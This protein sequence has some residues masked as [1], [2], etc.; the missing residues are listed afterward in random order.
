MSDIRD[1]IKAALAECAAAT[2]RGFAATSEKLLNTLGYRSERKVALSGN[3]AEF[4]RAYPATET[5]NADKFRKDAANVNIVFQFAESEI[6]D[7]VQRGLLPPLTQFRKKDTASFLFVAADLRPKHYSR[8]DYADFVREINKRFNAPTVALFR[9]P[10]SKDTTAALTLAFVGRRQSKTRRGYD[11]LQKVS[12]LREIQCDH[13]HRGHLDILAQLSLVERFNWMNSENKSQNFDG[14]L[15]AWLDEL[16]AEALNRR[17]YKALYRWFEWARNKAVFPRLPRVQPDRAATDAVI[18]L[19]TRMM[20]IWFIKEKKLVADELFSENQISPLLANYDAVKGDTYYRAILQNLF[21][22]TLNTEIRRRGFNLEG[23]P[24]HRNGHGYRYKTLMANPKKILELMKQTPFINGGLF[25]CL[26]S[27]EGGD[28][29]ADMFSDPIPGT[30]PKAAAARK[31][32]FAKLSVPNFLFFQEKKDPKEQRGLLAIFKKYKFTVEE[33]TPVEQEV[34]LDPELLG[35]VFENLLA[36]VNPET[37]ESARNQTGSFYTPRAI[38]DY[39]TDESIVDYLAAKVPGNGQW[40]QKLRDLLDYANSEC[41]PSVKE[42]SA[43]LVGAI[44][45][46]KVLDPACGSGAFPMGVL[47]KLALALSKLDPK[48]K[49]WKKFQKKRATVAARKIFDRVRG[50]ETRDHRL[51][52]I[53]NTFTKYSKPFGRKIFLIQNSIFGA[54]IQPIA[55]QIAKLR[56]FISLAIEQEKKGTAKNNFGIRP[57]P[58]LE[59]RFVAA[60]A[61]IRIRGMK[62]QGEL[63]DKRILQ[64]REDLANNREQHFNACIRNAKNKCRKE[65]KRLRG[66]LAA[67]LQAHGIATAPAAKKI[68][69]WNPY[70]QNAVADWFD[71]KWMFGDGRDFD[72]V[73]GNPP[74]I[75]LEADKGRLADLYRPQKYATFTGN[76]DIYCLFYERGLDLLSADGHLAYISS[77]KF[78]RTNYGRKLRRLFADKT[79][80]RTVI[81][82]GEN[83]VF[84]AGVD[85]AIVLM[86]NAASPKV[87][88][89]TA[90]VIKNAEDVFQV[91]SAV[92]NLGF[93]M[94]QSDL[95]ESEWTLTK[96]GVLAVIKKMRRAGVPMK[97]YVRKLMQRGITTGRDKAFVIDTETRRW[98][99]AEDRKSAELI[100]P[101]LDGKEIRK[102]RMKDIGEFVIFANKQTDIDCYPA[103]KR[104]LTR[105][106]T[107]LMKRASPPPKYWYALQAPGALCGDFDKPKIVYGD[108]SKEM[109][110]FIDRAGFCIGA[111]SYVIFADDN[112]YL[113]GV[114]NSELMDFFY[115]HTFPS[116][117]DP[118]NRG[119]VQFKSFKMAAVPIVSAD[120][121][122]RKEIARRVSAILKSPQSDSVPQL[123]MEIDALVYKLYGMTKSEIALIKEWQAIRRQADQ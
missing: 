106:K 66:L 37:R 73:I 6:D 93:E 63:G 52:E 30:H 64:L 113:L 108:T 29:R 19:I 27:E 91:D 90:A 2:S 50:Q 57:L 88:K 69:D 68:S 76:G 21:F 25:D 10:A 36:E 49:E 13:P 120:A 92:A 67:E 43:P 86:K 26:D 96:P 22:A 38:V 107:S 34:A 84:E 104:H 79:T 80:L 121:I 1:D 103:I 48:N 102:W 7:S 31:K 41:A 77:N 114:L 122:R 55:C 117:G 111:R 109:H 4:M 28:F 5:K 83:P 85:P 12:L 70:D 65:D 116:F 89:F 32:A 105:Y 35:K 45:D 62:E 110:A 123:E 9:R 87:P 17:F 95:S 44:A 18:R 11:V 8:S 39:M 75:Q 98:L 23:Q 42:K 118:W 61:L 24:G 40:R 16:D 51:S 59:T 56:F 74:Y 97:K 101:W 94:L 54:D 60:D 81:D 14:L 33:N 72:I 78:M 112:E 53:N 3:V 100:K 20:F 15:A 82:F 119:R 71:S 99:I 46:I 47:N 115:R 58:N